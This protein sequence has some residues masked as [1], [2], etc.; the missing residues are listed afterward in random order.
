MIGWGIIG[1]GVI[2][3]TRF[4]PALRDAPDSKLVAV[5]D[6]D[7]ARAEEL[8]R[9]HGAERAYAS[10]EDLCRDRRVDAIYIATPPRF[11]AEGTILAAQYRK[12]VI[13]EKPMAL[14]VAEAERMLRAVEKSGCRLAIGYMMPFHGSH[15][16]M[17]RL[18]DQG[19]V[20]RISMVK[21]DYLIS[22]PEFQGPSFAEDQFRLQRAAGGGVSMDLAPHCI[23]TIRYL[24][25]SEVRT[26]SAM[27]DT[28]RFGC[29]ADDT[30]VFVAQYDNDVL[31]VISLSF[32]I[33]W[34]HNGIEF[35][36]DRGALLS[37]QSLSQE[38]GGTVRSYLSGKWTNH[39]IDQVNPY[40][41]EILHFVECMRTG[42]QPI[43]SGEMGLADLRV[44]E[45]LRKSS[46]TGMRVRL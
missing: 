31:G 26:V 15:M 42:G 36:G 17:K 8:A 41:G 34:G 9:K 39:A 12:H 6:I 18:L 13:C 44:I 29:D 46:E 23:N 5:A 32:G 33:E 4:A 25:G 37:E 40:L 21:S 38:A 10:A 22:L 7:H 35:Y 27:C 3:D 24:M 43:T 19:I 45:A 16:A 2:A 28:L 30:A 14:N 20:G 11:H 1:C